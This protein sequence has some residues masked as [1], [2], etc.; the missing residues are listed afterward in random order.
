MYQKLM[1]C[2]SSVR[3]RTDFKPEIGLILGS[4]LGDYAD[5]IQIE[6]IVAYSAIEGFPVSTVK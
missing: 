3:E 4:G 5:G 1:T 6:S 2:V